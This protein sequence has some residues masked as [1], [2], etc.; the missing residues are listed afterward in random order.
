MALHLALHLAMHAVLTWH[1]PQGIRVALCP[2]VRS[3]SPTIY[4]MASNDGKKRR[5]KQDGPGENS[6]D[7]SSGRVTSDSLLSVRKQIAYAKAY[8]A[9]KSRDTRPVYRTS[10]RRQKKT[11]QDEGDDEENA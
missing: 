9:Y 8:Q 11:A 4:C 1:A 2:P 6:A 7:A 10:F 5:K 3:R